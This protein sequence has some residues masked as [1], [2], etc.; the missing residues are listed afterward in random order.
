[1]SIKR[2]EKEEEE[3][4]KEKRELLLE[5]LSEERNEEIDRQF[6]IKEEIR[7]AVGKLKLRKA[8][9]IDSIPMEA[10]IYGGSALN[11]GL[12]EIL[13]QMWNG[14]EIPKDWRTNNI[15]VPIFKKGDQEKKENYK[16]ISLL[17]TAYRILRG[18]LRS[19]LRSIKRKVGKGGGQTGPFTGK[20]RRIQER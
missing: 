1:M 17:C 11:K 20:S 2:E 19:R 12:T 18:R 4:T 6:Q 16:G 8:A 5:S 15:I 14:E 13:E 10:W 3:E 9:G 7:K